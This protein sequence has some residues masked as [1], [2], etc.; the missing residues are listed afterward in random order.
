MYFRRFTALCLLLT[1][2]ASSAAGS[3]NL[4][5]WILIFEPQN[6]VISQVVTFKYQSE[7]RSGGQGASPNPKNEQNGP[8]PVEISV[9][10]RELTLDGT[11][12]YP[13]SIGADDFVVYPSQF[14]LY[15]GDTKKV[16]VQWVGVKV[17]E[18]EIS[19]GFVATQVPLNIT[20]PA[21]Q[22]K[23][24]VTRVDV[25]TRYE[26]I[27]VVRP[28]NIKP[29]VVVDT[30]YSRN[31]TDGT[32]LVMILNNKGTGMQVLKNLNYTLSPLDKNGKI[33]FNER[34]QRKN[35]VPSNSTNQSLLAGFRRKVDVL[36][37]EGFPVGPVNATV[38]F[39]D[40]PK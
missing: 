17:P 34:I 22:P 24:A 11:V 23:T 40:V 15:P 29:N 21:E 8:I 9:S 2:I 7:N 28:P 3:F 18:K 26:G 10:A 16:Q 12:I 36:W 33:R 14:I 19:F 39:P 31:D 4:S 30:A 27:I 13:N 38:S 5:P 6:K 32:H 37:P 35:S 25:V 1:P 20:P